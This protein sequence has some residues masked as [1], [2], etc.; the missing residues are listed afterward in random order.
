CGDG[1]SC[2][3]EHAA[4]VA[5]VAKPSMAIP[6]RLYM[7][8]S[9]SGVALAT[10]R[11]VAACGRGGH[12]P[13][14]LEPRTGGVRS[15]ASSER[16]SWSRASRWWNEQVRPIRAHAL[17][18]D[19]AI[20]LQNMQRVGD[21]RLCRTRLVGEDSDRGV[22]RQALDLP[23][24]REREGR[25]TIALF[26]TLDRRIVSPVTARIHHSSAAYGRAHRMTETV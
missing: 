16:R 17:V 12:M 10:V 2:A 15:V 6:R 7:A 26:R 9:L 25:P 24:R 23:H 8:R 3:G 11:V 13:R 4:I 5:A 20:T 1:C 14:A 18:S 21:R 19:G 22:G